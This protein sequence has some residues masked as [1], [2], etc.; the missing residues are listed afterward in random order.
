MGHLNKF[1]L[2]HKVI[3]LINQIA[4][5]KAHIM[6]MSL[7]ALKKLD[8]LDISSLTTLLTTKNKSKMYW[9]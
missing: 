5:H 8:T 3:E 6:E 1:H 4:K 9:N 7:L 2:G